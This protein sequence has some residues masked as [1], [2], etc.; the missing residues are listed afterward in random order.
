MFP[1]EDVL[2]KM[3][4]SFVIIEYATKF[5]RMIVSVIVFSYQCIKFTA[6]KLDIS[7]VT[8]VLVINYDYRAKY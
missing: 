7:S 2:D 1:N 4:K 5:T 6:L 3:S 8:N